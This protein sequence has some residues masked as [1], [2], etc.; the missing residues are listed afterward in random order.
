MDHIMRIYLAK[1]QPRVKW[2][3]P[4]LDLLYLALLF[5][6]TSL[7]WILDQI[8]TSNYYKHYK[9]YVEIGRHL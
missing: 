9:N 5:W 7:K 6:S 4:V 2:G 1:H 8:S 3:L